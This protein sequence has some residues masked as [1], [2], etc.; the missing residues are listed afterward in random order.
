VIKRARKKIEL[1]WPSLYKVRLKEAFFI[2]LPVIVGI[3]GFSF[4]ITGNLY[5]D[6]FATYR[7]SVLEKPAFNDWERATTSLIFLMISKIGYLLVEDP[8]GIRLS[9]L[10]FAIATILMVG[11][12]AKLI[13][14]K[15][16]RLTAMWLTA[17][18]PMLIEFGGEGRPYAMMV[19]WGSAFLISFIIFEK[20]ETWWTALLLGIVSALGCLSRTIFAANL[21]FAVI[22]YLVKNRN[23][24][25]Y[26]VAA[27]LI[28]APALLRVL[29]LLFMYES[30]APKI[31]EGLEGVSTINFILRAG[32]A[33]NFGYCTFSLPE[34]GS[35]RNVPFFSILREN[36]P[37]VFMILIAAVGI[38]IGGIGFAKK[39]RRAFLLL[40]GFIIIPSA[41]IIIAGQLGYTIVREKFLISVLGGY[42]VLLS[43]VFREL[44]QKKIGWVPV[45]C[46][47]AVV[48]I[49]FLQQLLALVCIIILFY[50]KYILGVNCTRH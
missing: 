33:F 45:L 34:I 9:S 21:A 31:T 1:F 47:A 5:G 12:L 27:S 48:G 11:E 43:A 41:G 32:F 19:F 10:F 36:L 24:T 18:S 23:V 15:E 29:I 3:I 46:F 49:S 42:L 39:H 25:K 26:A 4:H 35:A 28:V 17:L 44:T 6:E 2:L 40:L 16:Y 30:K 22:Y 7:F 37:V 50:P 13:L 20:N 38:F 8:W 14:G